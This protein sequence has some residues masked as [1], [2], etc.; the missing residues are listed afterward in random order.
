[1]NSRKL[2]LGFN[3]TPEARDA[4]RLAGVLGR[5][6]D[7]AQVLAVSAYELAMLPLTVLDPEPELLADAES[8][9]QEVESALEGLTV[10]PLV[11]ASSS[12]ARAL[13]DTAEREGADLIVIGSTHRGAAGRVLLGSVGERLLH[14]GPCAVA[15]APRGYRQGE[16]FGFGLIGVAYDG[17]PEAEH[18]VAQAGGIAAATGAGVRLIGVLPP[19]SAGSGSAREDQL[20]SEL[21]ERIESAS[22]AIREQGV[23]AEVV[24][25]EG[26]PVDVLSD[27]GVE[28][29]LLVLGSRGY[30]PLKRTLLGGVSSRVMDTS[31]CPVLVVPRG[32]EGAG[33]PG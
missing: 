17:G 9:S 6:G 15:I 23:E 10:R 1:M 4:L 24:V 32:A 18:A 22:R 12:P 27:Q 26:E 8:Y 20:R 28:L 14:G 2:V 33:G 11:V 16:H 19:A 7:P 31:P 29:D 3:G 5:A 21:S 13:H 25:R 30:G